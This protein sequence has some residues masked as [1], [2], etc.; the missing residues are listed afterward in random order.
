MKLIKLITAMPEHTM[1]GEGI[2]GTEFIYNDDF[3]LHLFIKV[4]TIYPPN[5]RS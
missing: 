4:R 2:L 1:F 3:L 5:L